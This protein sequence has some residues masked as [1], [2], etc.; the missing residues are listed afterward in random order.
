MISNCIGGQ[1]RES[2]TA[3]GLRNLEVVDRVDDHERGNVDREH[4]TRTNHRQH[5]EPI[6][7]ARVEVDVA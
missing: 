2:Y 7:T 3:I 4:Q 6:R 5:G 1:W